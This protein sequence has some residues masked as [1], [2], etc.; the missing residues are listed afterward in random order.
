MM[1]QTEHIS[2]VSEW[3]DVMEVI[4]GTTGSFSLLLL[5]VQN[6]HKELTDRENSAFRKYLINSVS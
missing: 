6:P 2:D 4:I 3:R 5:N 1:L